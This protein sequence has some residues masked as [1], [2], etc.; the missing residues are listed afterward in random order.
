MS[1]FL[2]AAA[3]SLARAV[4]VPASE[5][6]SHAHTRINN[7]AKLSHK[8]SPSGPPATQE[9]E[10]ERDRQRATAE[11]GKQ[12]EPAQSCGTSAAAEDAAEPTLLQLSS[13]YKKI[14]I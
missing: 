10:R 12:Q 3:H 6:A 8:F 1:E 9:R 13:F 11:R 5:L 2:T 4:P 14:Q 7:S